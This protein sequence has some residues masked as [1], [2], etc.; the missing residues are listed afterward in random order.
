[1]THILYKLTPNQN[2]FITF[3]AQLKFTETMIQMAAIWIISVVAFFALWA[4][5]ASVI[6][7]ISERKVESGELK[8]ESGKLKVESEE[9]EQEQIN[10]QNIQQ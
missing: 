1:M 6:R 9:I 2:T 4:L 7:K 10:Q 8:V 3:A 5:L